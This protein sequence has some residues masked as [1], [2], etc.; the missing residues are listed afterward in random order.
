MAKT[1]NILGPAP[2]R[3]DGGLKVTGAAK[4]SVE[5]DVPKCAYGW[6]V[7]SSIAK[8]KILSVDTK[9]AQTVPG[10][11]AVVTH[12]NAPKPM[13][14]AAKKDRGQ[15]HG[16][17][18]EERVPFSDDQIYY[19]G[20]YV[21]LVVAKTI[22]Q[23]RYAASLVKVSYA[24]EEPALTMEASDK[25]TKPKESFGPVQIKK[26]DVDL[27]LKDASLTKI[28]QT[29]TT[30]TETHNPIE[31]SGTIAAWDGDDKLT[32]YDATQFG[33]G[34]QSVIARAWNL[35][36]AKTRRGCDEQKRI[37]REISFRAAS[38]KGYRGSHVC[39]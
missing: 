2:S 34:V 38:L 17:R 13:E 6:T 1:S 21:A 37:E 25:A 29:Y 22:E 3:V 8:G 11:L 24:P 20:Q 4:Y 15:T 23:A 9:A 32:L 12:L 33:K 28:E 39:Q 7:E 14:P 26:G 35:W 36:K 16:I 27:A 18:N 10:V 5:F 31:M 30:P 19:A